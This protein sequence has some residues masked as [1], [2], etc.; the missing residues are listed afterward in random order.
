[1]EVRNLSS[2]LQN[3]IITSVISKSCDD[4]NIIKYRLMYRNSGGAQFPSK[5][6]INFNKSSKTCR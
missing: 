3:Y 1:M 5:K 2:K 4:L 6:K